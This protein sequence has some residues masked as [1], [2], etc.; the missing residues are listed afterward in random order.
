MATRTQ[1][2]ADFPDLIAKLY[3]RWALDGL[4]ELAYAVSLDFAAKP[5]SY[6]GPD[7]PEVISD[8]R[9]AYGTDK[10]FQ[11]TAQRQAM[12]LPILGRSDGLKPDQSVSAS[13]F[14]V[15]R[16]AFLDACV[17]FSERTVDT[18]LAGLE[19]RV[20]SSLL[21]FRSHFEGL[22]GTA[23][24]M[25]S[26]LITDV[27]GHAAQILKAPGVAKVFG[28]DPAGGDWPLS[29]IDANGAKLV[30]AIGASLSVPAEYKLAQTKFILLQQIAQ[31]GS[32]TL[33]LVLRT[34]PKGSSLNEV[35][36]HGYAWCSSLRDY[37]QA[38]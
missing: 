8:F 24:Q 3:S 25:A 6:V 9:V 37:Q 1:E 34:D 26:H 31:E 16:K 7:I 13:K 5:Q 33:P 23:V 28:Q 22:K 21:T 12:V 32:K 15:T 38:A 2:S 10:H 27:S 29:S 36:K 11:N 20:Q 14:H 4:I 18:G 19:A 17:A 30:E 35:I